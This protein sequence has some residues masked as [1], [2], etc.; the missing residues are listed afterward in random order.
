MLQA[1]FGENFA[2]LLRRAPFFKAQFRLIHNRLAKSDY[3]LAA[4]IDRFAN[5]MFQLF[6]SA[7]SLAP[8]VGESV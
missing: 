2:H 1:E 6:F 8:F 4:A 7:H 3:P 5:R